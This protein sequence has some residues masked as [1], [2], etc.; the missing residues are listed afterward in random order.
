MEEALKKG[1]MVIARWSTL[2]PGWLK[3]GC[4]ER[5]GEHKRPNGHTCEQQEGAIWQLA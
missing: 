1:H 3:G 5:A 2:I 4:Y